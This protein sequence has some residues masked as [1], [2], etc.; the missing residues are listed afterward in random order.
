MLSFQSLKKIWPCAPSIGDTPLHL[1]FSDRLIKEWSPLVSSLARKYTVPDRLPVEDLKQELMCHIWK[2]TERVDP[3]TKPD[4]FARL[5]RTE[6]RNKCVDLNRHM[7]A[8][9]RMGR[10]GNAIQ[11]QVCGSV[12]RIAFNGLKECEFCGETRNIREVET[13]AR[14]VSIGVDNTEDEGVSLIDES[15]SDPLDSM[16]SDELIDR[17]RSAIE[18]VDRKVYD[19]L[20]DPSISFL[21]FLR[22]RGHDSDHRIA[23][24]RHYAEFLNLSE[25]QVSD[26]HTRI[27]VAIMHIANAKVGDLNKVTLRRLDLA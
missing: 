5:C 17:V 24:N 1:R 15:S 8:R 6:L 27:K 25:R 21:S 26:A 23:A 16:I 20:V 22:S 3:I 10:T 7:K 13:Y 12:T 18:A 19:M 4:D 11:C 14:N 9:K 2:L